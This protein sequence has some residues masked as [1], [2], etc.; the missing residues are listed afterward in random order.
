MKFVY[1]LKSKKNGSV[2]VGN[3]DDVAERFKRHN[4]GEVI[5]TK[6]RRPWKLSCYIAFEDKIKAYNLE[7]YLKSGSDRAFTNK[8]FA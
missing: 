1:I 4:N 2:Y 3:T 6:D 7:R 8:H 5:S